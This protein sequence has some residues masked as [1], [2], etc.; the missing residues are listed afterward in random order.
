MKDVVES[1]GQMSLARKDV[2]HCWARVVA[3]SNSYFNGAGDAIKQSRDARSHQICIRMRRDIDF[4]QAAWLYE[5]R[6]QSGARWFKILDMREQNENGQY[7]EFDCRVVERGVSLQ[8]PKPDAPAP[9]LGAVAM[10]AGV[11]L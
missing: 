8:P 10:P 3:T 4:T 9:V 7:F 5:E 1:G 2:Y 11:R 6:L